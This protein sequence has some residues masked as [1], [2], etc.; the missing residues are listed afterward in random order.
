MPE[1]VGAPLTAI[2]FVCTGLA[3]FVLMRMR[4]EG[5]TMTTRAPHLTPDVARTEPG[6]DLQ[7]YRPPEPGPNREPIQPPPPVRNRAD[8]EPRLPARVVVRCDWHGSFFSGWC[9]SP[10]SPSH[11]TVRGTAL[12]GGSHEATESC[13]QDVV[14]AAWEPTTGALYLA[15]ADGLGSLAKSGKIAYEAVQAA[16]HLSL[17]RPRGL[18]FREAGERFF[19][20]ISDG[21]RRSFGPS[22]E[23]EGGTTLVVAEI[24]PTDEGADVTVHAVGD[25]EAWMLNMHGWRPVHDERNAPGAE[26]NATRDLPNDPRPQTHQ[27]SL[28]RGSALLL[29]TDGFAS[30][31]YPDSSLEKYLNRRWATPPAI[32]E[33]GRAHV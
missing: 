32:E 19:A 30:S 14:G 29:A 26:D 5:R 2:A 21:L 4:P 23:S 31:I 20:A 17:N 16:F 10:A 11:L 8:A 13:G 18:T 15:V 3:I 25:S 9:G 22:V 1:W 27:L 12:R 24:L 7:L 33:I 6:T 28:L